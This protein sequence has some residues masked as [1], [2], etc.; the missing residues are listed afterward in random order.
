MIHAGFFLTKWIYLFIIQRLYSNVKYT[1][2]RTS[3][4]VV[5]SKKV[6]FDY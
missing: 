1:N 3:S 6:D 5:M 2:Y 4:V